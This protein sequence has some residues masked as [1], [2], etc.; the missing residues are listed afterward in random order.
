MKCP[1]LKYLEPL[2]PEE[3]RALEEQLE[4]GEAALKEIGAAIYWTTLKLKRLRARADAI[5]RG[6]SHARRRLKRLPIEAPPV[7]F[8]SIEDAPRDESETELTELT[9]VNGYVA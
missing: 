2:T 9:E 5:M 6:T 1:E 7:N 3:M 4:S 8:I